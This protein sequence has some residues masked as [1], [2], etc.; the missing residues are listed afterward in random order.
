[1][2]LNNSY[3]RN[4]CVPENAFRVQGLGLWRFRVSRF[5]LGS[6]TLGSSKFGLETGTANSAAEVAFAAEGFEGV[7]IELEGEPALV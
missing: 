4:P 6:S 1:M 3:V 5:S 7:G 2:H